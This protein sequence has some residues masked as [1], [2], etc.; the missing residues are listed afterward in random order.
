MIEAHE[1]V[2][3]MESYIANPY[4]PEVDALI[5]LQ[6]KSGMNFQRTDEKRAATLLAYLQQC[7][8]TM[9]D[10][11]ALEA[12]SQRP[13]YRLDDEDQTSEIVMPRH[14]LSG[15]LVQTCNVSPSSVIKTSWAEN[16]RTILRLEPWRTGKVQADKVFARYVKGESNQRRYQES[17]EIDDFDAHGEIR[18]DPDVIKP[19]KVEALL[20]YALC[21]VGIGACRKMAYGRGEFVSLT[22]VQG[23]ASA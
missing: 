19:P 4:W 17:P 11:R 16:L 9:D 15:A 6:K 7:G 20:K 13:W 8:M 23:S 18:F 21:N 1:V 14:Q 3:H 12:K 10:Y 2:V 5:E 22:P